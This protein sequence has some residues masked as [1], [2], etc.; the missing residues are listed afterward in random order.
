M[1]RTGKPVRC[2]LD[3]NEDMLITG[4]RHP[5]LCKYKV[6]FNKDGK[7]QALEASVYSNG[8]SSVDCSTIVSIRFTIQCSSNRVLI[9]F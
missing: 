5:T 4:G 9:S 2:M 7:I 8:G 6:G 1:F 3:R